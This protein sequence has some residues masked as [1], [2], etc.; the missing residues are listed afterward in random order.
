MLKMQKTKTQK[1]KKTEPPTSRNTGN[2]H[3]QTTYIRTY[4]DLW[5]V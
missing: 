3:M 4:T 1:Q 5:M 2:T